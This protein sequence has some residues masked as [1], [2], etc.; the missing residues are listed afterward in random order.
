M[1]SDWLRVVLLLSEISRSMAWKTKKLAS[2]T[3]IHDRDVFNNVKNDVPIN[4]VKNYVPIK[5]ECS[6]TKFSKKLYFVS[7]QPT[8][9]F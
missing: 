4:N 8:G 7:E 9:T 1:S 5:Q 2:R 3:F 6:T